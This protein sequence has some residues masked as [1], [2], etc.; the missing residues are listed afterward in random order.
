MPRGVPLMT[1]VPRILSAIA[2]GDLHAAEQLLPLV[3]HELRGLLFFRPG[4]RFSRRFGV[5]KG[6]DLL[7]KDVEPDSAQTQSLLERVQSGDRLAF[8]ELFARHRPYLRQLVELRLDPK[9][10]ARVDFRRP[11]AVKILKEEYK[12]RPDMA[13]RFLDEA[14]IT[15]QLQHPGV[16]PVH[17]IG[18]LPDNRP[19]LAMKLI[20]GRTLGELLPKRGNPADRLQA[21][22]T[23]FRQVCQTLAF[24]HSHGVI[25]RDL[26]PANIMVGAFGEVQVM[27]WG[28]A[29]LRRR[30]RCRDRM[31]CHALPAIRKR[32]ALSRTCRRS[33]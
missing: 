30:S 27:D 24:A 32:L 31:S 17:E 13:A 23:I 19:F 3:S 1:Y 14:K 12:D 16:P 7:M 11:L 8:D 33:G 10:R 28:L 26:K 15:G 25:H 21:Y 9:L 4:C 18:T 2:Q 5:N 20:K 22:V 6:G 29:K